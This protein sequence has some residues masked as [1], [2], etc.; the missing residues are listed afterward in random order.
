MAGDSAKD[1]NRKMAPL[2]TQLENYSAAATCLENVIKEETQEILKVGLYTKMAGNYK[3]ADKED[4]CIK[5]SVDAYE[6]MLKLS[7]AKDAQ[8]CRCLVNLA[9]VY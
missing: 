5:A 4:E 7:N 8:T 2:L 6:L 9:Q 1:I 3:K